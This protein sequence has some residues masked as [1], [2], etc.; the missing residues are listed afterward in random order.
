[1]KYNKRKDSKE[2]ELSWWLAGIM[3]SSL[4][5]ATQKTEPGGCTHT[6]TRDSHTFLTLKNKI[7]TQ[8][9]IYRNL[10]PVNTGKDNGLA[11]LF[12]QIKQYTPIFGFLCL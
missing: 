2:I 5:S 12:E 1:M 11:K 9:N 7:K 10:V 4:V 6:H 8:G 3:A